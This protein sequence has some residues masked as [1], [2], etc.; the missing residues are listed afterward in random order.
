[1]EI[2][3]DSGSFTRHIL[4][5]KFLT[6]AQVQE[7]VDVVDDQFRTRKL[8]ADADGRV[9]ASRDQYFFF[10]GA[11]MGMLIM[12]KQVKRHYEDAAWEQGVDVHTG[13]KIEDHGNA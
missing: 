9:D 10:Q 13:E 7:V 8:A 4:G 6:Q 11:V 5:D 1:M 3:D 12:A 2:I